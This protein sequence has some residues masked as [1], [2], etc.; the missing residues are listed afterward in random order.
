MEDE[1]AEVSLFLKLVE[2]EGANPDELRKLRTIGYLLGDS[3][4]RTE[5]IK[6]F[7][8]QYIESA[9]DRSIVEELSLLASPE[10]FGD[11]FWSTLGLRLSSERFYEVLMRVLNASPAIAITHRAMG[12]AVDYLRFFPQSFL[13]PSC[14]V[15]ILLDSDNFD[16]RVIGLKAS[17]DS[18]VDA[19]EIVGVIMRGLDARVFDEIALSLF[20]LSEILRGRR[21]NILR[22]IDDPLLQNVC[23]PLTKIANNP[24]VE[25]DFRGTSQNVLEQIRKQF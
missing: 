18:E 15:R 2:R 7:S 10:E 5:L 12:A 20:I 1:R 9:L 11:V 6:N 3:S 8:S 13:L 24:T 25:I 14:S 21:L 4:L 23:D 17:L 19:M 16:H 22:E